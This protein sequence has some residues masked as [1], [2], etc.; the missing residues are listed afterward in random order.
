MFVCFVFVVVDWFIGMV[1]CV[2][3]FKVVV[4]GF[5]CF[6]CVG[7]TCWVWRLFIFCA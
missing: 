3:V 6:Y 1:V 7:F 4:V 2:L 5:V